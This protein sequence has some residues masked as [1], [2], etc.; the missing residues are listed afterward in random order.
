MI[1]GDG[2]GDARG[3][4]VIGPGHRRI[5]RQ[6]HRHRHRGGGR[7]A[8]PRRKSRRNRYRNG[9]RV[10]VDRS[11]VQA[12]VDAG[13]VA[14]HVVLVVVD[15][16][17]CGGHGSIAQPGGRTR[18]RNGAVGRLVGEIVDRGQA[19]GGPAGGFAL[20]DGDAQSRVVHRF[21]IGPLGCAR[22][23]AHIQ[24]NRQRGLLGVM[25][26]GGYR[27]RFGGAVLFYLIRRRGEGHIIVVVQDRYQHGRYRTRV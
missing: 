13:G 1:G 2:D 19:E 3:G 23:G 16:H 24:V 25:Q 22:S 26:G 9:A 15:R 5:V 12:Q 6:P 10:L 14:G 18:N 4:G 11:L 20:G 8:L 17:R 7:A 27:D 21:E